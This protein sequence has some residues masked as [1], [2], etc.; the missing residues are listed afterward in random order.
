MDYA[1]FALL[2]FKFRE[3][4]FRYFIIISSW[5]MALPFIW[6]KSNYLSKG[7]SVLRLVEIGPVV[8]QKKMKIEKNIYKLLDGR[9][10]I[11]EANLSFQFRWAKKVLKNDKSVIKHV[12]VCAE[13]VDLYAYAC[14]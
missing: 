7:C 3:M 8:L 14:S 12:Y 6:T 13:H 2:L 4:Y 1:T 10:I 11:R 5:K 9:Q